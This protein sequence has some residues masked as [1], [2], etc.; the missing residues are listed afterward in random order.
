MCRNAKTAQIKYPLLSLWKYLF[1][2]FY[3]FI[4]PVLFADLRLLRLQYLTKYSFQEEKNSSG[5][6]LEYGMGSAPILLQDAALWFPFVFFELMLFTCSAFGTYLYKIWGY[7]HEIF[8]SII[9]ENNK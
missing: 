4:A 9:V 5:K 8:W 6:S 3:A 2:Q 7:T 1:T